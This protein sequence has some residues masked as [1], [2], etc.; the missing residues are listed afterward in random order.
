MCYLIDEILESGGFN[1][2]L[3]GIYF[4]KFISNDL[5]MSLIEKGFTYKIHSSIKLKK[6]REKEEVDLI[7]ELKDVVLIAEIKCI[8]FSLTGRDYANAYKTLKK[9][10]NQITRKSSYIRKHN[11]SFD[12]LEIN[13]NKKIIIA[14][15]NQY[16]LF[17][18]TKIDDVPIL[19]YPVIESYFKSGEFSQKKSTT[20][21]IKT[22]SEMKYYDDENTFNANLGDYLNSPVP[23]RSLLSHVKFTEDEI[24]PAD[25]IPSIFTIN[26]YIDRD[27]EIANYGISRDSI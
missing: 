19:D 1:L 21:G 18:G 10:A 2:D 9:A 4:E 7:V 26:T 23:L 20:E 22:I 14:V 17:T 15:I 6:S 25:S 12:N 3:R 27:Y 24:T 13:L 5:E 16:P 11:G 8:K